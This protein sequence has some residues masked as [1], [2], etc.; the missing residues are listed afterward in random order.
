MSHDP[1]A[2]VATAAIVSLGLVASG[3]NNS[4][5][6]ARQAAQRAARRPRTRRR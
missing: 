1:D 6:A 4:R 3:T 5:R 2:D